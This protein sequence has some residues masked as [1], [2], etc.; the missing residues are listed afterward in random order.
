MQS[1]RHAELKT[2]RAL[3][4]LEALGVELQMF[5][6][7]K[8]YTVTRFDDTLSGRHVVRV[9]M[10][11]VSDRT[12]ILGGDTRQVRVRRFRPAFF[13]VALQRPAADGLCV[14]STFLAE[15]RIRQPIESH[16]PA[17]SHYRIDPLV[18]IGPCVRQ[19]RQLSPK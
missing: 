18:S 10:K 7:A 14:T 9:Q 8:P 3:E 11:D 12:A 15:P 19:G 16:P 6:D 5:Y 13:S 17:S 4:H 1:L 2:S